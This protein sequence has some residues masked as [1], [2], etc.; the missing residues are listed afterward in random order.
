MATTPEM[1]PLSACVHAIQG[2]AYPAIGPAK[3]RAQGQ[4][5]HLI[6]RVKHL[7]RLARVGQRRKILKKIKLPA[8]SFPNIPVLS[9][10]L[11][12]ESNRKSQTHKSTKSATQ[13]S[14]DCPARTPRCP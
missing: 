10:A 8:N 11:P 5:Q 3:H 6:K 2:H 4:Q 1:A 9:T 13:N 7:F 14:F 12:I